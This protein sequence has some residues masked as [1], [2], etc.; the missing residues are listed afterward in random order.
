MHLHGRRLL[1]LDLDRLRALATLPVP[2]VLHGATSIA[3]ADLQAA[4]E[5]GVRKINVGS[6]LKQAFLNTLRVAC[7][8]VPLDANPCEAIGSG[9]DGD[10]LLEGRRAM[11]AEVERLMHLFGSKGRAEGWRPA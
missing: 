5:I 11:A 2:L 10:V 3:P 4:I 7:R 9:L 8:A 6:R 1:R